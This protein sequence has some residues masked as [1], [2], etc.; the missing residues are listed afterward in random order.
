MECKWDWSVDVLSDIFSLLSILPCYC[1]ALGVGDPVVKWGCS[2]AFRRQGKWRNELLI[3]LATLHL[4]SCYYWFLERHLSPS[5][6]Q[7]CIQSQRC[8]LLGRPESRVCYASLQGG[9][10]GHFGTIKYKDR[11]ECN[12]FPRSV[13]VRFRKQISWYI[14]CYRVSD[15]SHIGLWYGHKA[16]KISRDQNQRCGRT[17]TSIQM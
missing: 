1:R 15:L 9:K 6:P 17:Y 4:F 11:P 16:R 5:I 7:Y 12:W 2:L 13:R 14:C 10:W 8:W 3:S